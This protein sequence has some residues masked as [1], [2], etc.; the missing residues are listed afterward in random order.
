MDYGEAL[1]YIRNI[2]KEVKFLM[3]KALKVKPERS[4]NNVKNEND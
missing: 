4:E 3:C 2:P 1:Q